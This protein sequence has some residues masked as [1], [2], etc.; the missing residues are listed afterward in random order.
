LFGFVVIKKTEQKLYFSLRSESFKDFV[1]SFSKELVLHILEGFLLPQL[2][3][4]NFLVGKVARMNYFKDR[5]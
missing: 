4:E 3:A 1:W 5:E 2:F